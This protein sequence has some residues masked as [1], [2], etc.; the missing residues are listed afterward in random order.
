MVER[1]DGD[2]RSRQVQPLILMRQALVLLDQQDELHSARYL[3]TA[4]LAYE[5][6]LAEEANPS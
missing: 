2:L 1:N 3:H 6:W 5:S 4:I